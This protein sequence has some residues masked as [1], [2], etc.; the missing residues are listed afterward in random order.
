M[1]QLRIKNGPAKGTVQVL[2]DGMDTL[3]IGRE[4]H[5]KL[6]DSAASR[7]HAELFAISDMFFLRDL[8]SSNGTFVDDERLGPEDQVVLNPGDLI[9]IGSTYVVFEEPPPPATDHPGFSH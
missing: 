7:N 9:R 5:L 6:G 2:S 4:A 3:T 8:G 1:P